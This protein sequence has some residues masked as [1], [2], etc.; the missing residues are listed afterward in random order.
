MSYHQIDV[1][2]APLHALRFRRSSGASLSSTPPA[3]SDESWAYPNDVITHLPHALMSML[4][5]DRPLA[6]KHQRPDAVLPLIARDLVKVKWRPER[7]RPDGYRESTV[8]PNEG[9]ARTLTSELRAHRTYPDTAGRP[10]RRRRSSRACTYP[11]YPGLQETAPSHQP[12]KK[13][14]PESQ[15]ASGLSLYMYPMSRAPDATRTLARHPLDSSMRPLLGCSLV[16][17]L[18]PAQIKVGLRNVLLVVEVP[19]NQALGVIRPTSRRPAV[20]H[21]RIRICPQLQGARQR[22]DGQE[23]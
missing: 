4:D 6:C 17:H 1:G 20:E 9:S 14:H 7:R 11:D 3:C 13:R 21:F 19:E 10:D 8:N 12:A 22:S 5:D 15:S 23:P 18:A 16:R 2:N